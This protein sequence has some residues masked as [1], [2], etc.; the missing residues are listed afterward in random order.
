[1]QEQVEWQS[2]SRKKGKKAKPQTPRFSSKSEVPDHARLLN[3]LSDN[4]PKPLASM[5]PTVTTL[6]P[7][8][9]EFQSRECSN[10]S[11]GQK[12]QPSQDST[13]VPSIPQTGP[14]IA[15]ASH[16]IGSSNQ[17]IS[18]NPWERLAPPKKVQSNWPALYLVEEEKR[19]EEFESSRRSTTNLI[20]PRQLSPES[21]SHRMG[22]RVTTKET[23]AN[24]IPLNSSVKLPPSASEPTAKLAGPRRVK[25][26]LESSY[27][28][29]R[30]QNSQQKAL[31]DLQS[32]AM[33]PNVSTE[34]W[35]WRNEPLGQS[36]I[37][38]EN[39]VLPKRSMKQG[40]RGHSTRS[41]QNA[42]DRVAA[43]PVRPRPNNI[44]PLS[45][46]LGKDHHS[47]QTSSVHYHLTVEPTPILNSWWSSAASCNITMLS[48]PNSSSMMI[49][50][51]VYMQSMRAPSQRLWQAVIIF[52]Y[53]SI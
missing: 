41:Q 38:N 15:R 42:Q 20:L 2:A 18:G 50:Q 23:V 5:S 6:E 17:P 3:G 40:S 21:A 16:D 22:S 10:S 31:K 45:R 12:P 27:H 7:A 28:V 25:N 4:E 35:S 43:Y 26:A 39:S 24:L 33:E 51:D 36:T 1:M 19:E 53:P 48:G 52:A 29:D 47:D 9:P 30:D 49:L 32:E 11:S 37:D 46:S 8:E 34:N 44:A 14:S 13:A